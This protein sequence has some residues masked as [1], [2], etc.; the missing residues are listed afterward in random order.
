MQVSENSDVPANLRGV[1]DVERKGL[2]AFTGRM[3]R[4]RKRRRWEDDGARVE[5][6]SYDFGALGSG[7]SAQHEEVLQP[8]STHQSWGGVAARRVTD[9]GFS[10]R[11]F[12]STGLAFP[13]S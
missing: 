4:P 13:R 8:L 2:V 12:R 11:I 10:F 3:G 9:G 1:Q 6:L 5:G 7:G